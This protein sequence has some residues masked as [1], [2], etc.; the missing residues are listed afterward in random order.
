MSENRP[1]RLVGQDVG[2]ALAEDRARRDLGAVDLVLH[3]GPVW[4]CRVIL[5]QA[6]FEVDVHAPFGQFCGQDLAQ[7]RPPAV[8]ECVAMGRRIHRSPLPVRSKCRPHDP[9]VCVDV[10]LTGRVLDVNEHQGKHPGLG[11]L[12]LAIHPL[13][14]RLFL[15]L[16]E[17]LLGHGFQDGDRFAD[18]LVVRS[19][20]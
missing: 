2:A 5:R 9:D 3:R 10:S 8:L 7:G 18:A 17:G 1:S 19:R 20:Q 15:E 12:D 6:R 4:A 11:P 13:S 14:D 16:V